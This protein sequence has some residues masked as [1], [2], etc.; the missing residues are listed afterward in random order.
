M[1]PLIDMDSIAILITNKCVNMCSNCTQ[2]CGNFPK[3]IDMPFEQFK[4]AIDSM[5]KFPVGDSRSRRIIGF[6]GG[7]PLLHPEFEKFCDYAVSKIPQGRLGLWTTLPENKKHLR[8]VVTRTFGHIFINSH[9]RKDVMHGPIL[10]ASEEIPTE[11]WVKN[12]LIDHCWIQNSWSACVNTNG[13]FFCEVAAAL[14]LLLDKPG[15]SLGWSVESNWWKRVP[16][17]FAEQMDRYCKKCGVAM[18]LKK[19]ASVEEI[20]DISPAMYER[21][22]DTSPKLKAGKY[23][24]HNLKLSK[25]N[26]PMASY[27]DPITRQNAAARW[28]IQ[29][30]SPNAMGYMTPLLIPGWRIEDH[31]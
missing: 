22:K 3:P 31:S 4:Q 6:H 13:A 8:E 15:E 23:E 29:L 26:R 21:L 7:E 28:G 11:Q 10:V 18:P 20:E 19:R 2:S 1:R 27:K 5:E 30:I 12:Y 24:I 16:R 17:D 14:S 25:D 9:E